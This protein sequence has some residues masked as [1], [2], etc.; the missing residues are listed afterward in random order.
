MKS[1]NSAKRKSNFAVDNEKHVMQKAAHAVG[2]IA[3]GIA[4]KHQ[5]PQLIVF[6]DGLYH[7]WADGRLELAEK[8]NF[9]PIIIHRRKSSL[10]ELNGK[11]N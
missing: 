1:K 8:K 10:A 5:L 7:K 3:R 6:P 11:K 9:T 2:R 4:E